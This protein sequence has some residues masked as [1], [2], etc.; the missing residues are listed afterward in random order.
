MRFG[1]VSAVILALWGAAS[2]ADTR[3]VV[4]ELFTSQGCANCPPADAVLRELATR[5]DVIALAFH[6]DYW[7]YIGW[8]DTFA[9]PEFTQRQRAYG[10]AAGS[11][12]VYTP[13]VIIA[14]QD[15]VGGHQPMQI[16]DRIVHHSRQPNL[17]ELGFD[18]NSQTNQITIQARPGLGRIPGRVQVILVSYIPMA[19]VQITRGENAGL[20]AQYANIVRDITPIAIWQDP[21][22]P[23][24]AT[25]TP[26]PDL[27]QVVLFQSENHGPVLAA[28]RVP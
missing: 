27:D 12:M 23:F 19:E 21:T 11:S 20:T 3:P 18:P 25:I 2:Y 24:E 4:V 15:H 10:A 5:D 28:A 13:Q 7:D 16:A 22:T 26:A 6:V 14:G 17:V 8:E 9:K 1:F